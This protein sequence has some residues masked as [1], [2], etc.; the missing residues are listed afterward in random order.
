MAICI[1][2][3]A[4]R[5]TPFPLHFFHDTM[6]LTTPFRYALPVSEGLLREPL[7]V[8]YV[9][10]TQ[11]LA[12][13][14]Y[15]SSPENTPVFF[16]YLWNEGR[17]LPE[18]CMVLVCEGMG[19]LE[20]RQGIQQ[21]P[22]GTAYLLRPGEWH[23]NRP[24]PDTGW[25]IM[26][27]AFNGDLPRR[28][29]RE[30]TFDLDGNRA[31]S[32][33]LPTFIAQF[34]HLLRCVEND[35]SKNNPNLSYQL[36]GILS[37][38]LS[39]GLNSEAHMLHADKVIS[40]SLAYIWGNLQQTLTVPDVAAHVGVSRRVLERRFMKGVG[41][42]VLEEIQTCRID[43][44]KRLLEGTPTFLKEIATR[45]G[46]RS[47]AH[48]RQVFLNRFGYTPRTFRENLKSSSPNL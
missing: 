23:R 12:G 31:V 5:V 39:D 30:N 40:E 41:H 19:E 32:K 3:Q 11:V 25:T 21:I 27:I 34:E 15:E 20:T 17:I 44:A 7:H 45:T 14:P 16:R 33:D 29:I 18:F 42:S 36:I 13:E 22:P 2:L 8:T 35:P 38:F 26:W 10:W 43:R 47:A 6:P 46:F 37:H 1:E 9:G 28:W 4:Y 24:R 48:M